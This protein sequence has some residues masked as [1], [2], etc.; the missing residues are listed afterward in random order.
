MFGILFAVMAIGN[1]IGSPLWGTL[2][3]NKGRI[4]FWNGK[5]RKTPLFMQP[6]IRTIHPIVAKS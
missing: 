2:S 5:I 1:F 6:G 3:D 4:K